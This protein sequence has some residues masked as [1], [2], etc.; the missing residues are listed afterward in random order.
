MLVLMLCAAL[1][2]MIMFPRTPIGES[3]RQLL[4]ELPVQALSRLTPGRIILALILVAAGALVAVLFEAEGL[5]MLGMAVP[6]GLAWVVAFDVATVLD[7]F[8]AVA[9]VAAAA[10][11]RSLRDS[12]RSVAAWTRSRISRVAARRT[13]WSRRRRARRPASRPAKNDDG[14]GGWQAGWSPAWA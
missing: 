11:L 14:E 8:T 6:E 1:A 2:V 3:L 7:L 12:A 9:M 5:R 10:R 4:I 13:G